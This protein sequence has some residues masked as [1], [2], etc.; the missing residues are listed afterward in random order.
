MEVKI[1]S[2]PV[3]VKL[4]DL[5]TGGPLVIVM[6]P[7]DMK[8]LGINIEDR[9]KVCGANNDDI[10]AIVNETTRLVKEDEVG[11]SLELAEKLNLKEGQEIFLEPSSPP[12]SMLYIKKKMNDQVLEK[13]E[14]Y[15]I[16]NDIIEN[17]LSQIELAAFVTAMYINDLNMDEVEYM[18]RAIIDSGEKIKFEKPL[19]VDKHC[20]GGVA[21]NR[22]T[23][24]VVP[25]LAANGLC[26]PKTSSRSITSAAGTA[27]T[28][29]VLCP[30]DL[31]L[32]KIKSITN[33]IGAVITWGGAVSLAPADD[34]II[35][36]EHP[37]RADPRG[38]VIASVM[39]KKA[40]VG[41]NHLIIDIPM[42]PD[43]KVKTL[44]NAKALADDFVEIGKRLGIK[45]EALITKG[46]QPIGRAVGPA[47]E[48]RAVLRTLEGEIF[49]DLGEKSCELAGVLLEMTGKAEKGNGFD[50]AKKTIENGLA[51]K[52]MREIIKMQGGKSTVTSKSIKLAEYKKNVLSK[53][54]GYIEQISN[55]KTNLLARIAGSPK[56]K[57]AGLYFHKVVGE[58]VHKGDILFEV[59]AEN[60]QK[61]ESAISY[62][63][64]RHPVVLKKII[65]QSVE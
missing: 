57:K 39:A 23:M 42:G 30:V 59:H 62:L 40:S 9:V 61:L 48:A 43:T 33:K 45:T 24:L 2:I 35:K 12:E 44:K 21:G 6:H 36:V 55:K 7:N 52:K 41:S 27:D 29:E 25:I 13:S 1:Y 34:I 28:M 49:D 16:V 63:E 10:T 50:L 31:P 11:V 65:I 56:D 32:E 14:I 8:E 3:K 58:K 5:T 38:Q 22:T 15:K 20:I 51:L 46:D 19:I 64:K 26:M 37:L 54:E 47:L 18:T 4:L 17:N 53:R 60:K